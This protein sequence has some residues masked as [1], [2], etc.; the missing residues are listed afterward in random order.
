MPDTKCIAG[1]DHRLTL[2]RSAHHNII[3]VGLCQVALDFEVVCLE[4]HCLASLA[5]VGAGRTSC[6]CQ[7]LQSQQ[8]V[9]NDTE[10]TV[11]HNTCL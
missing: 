6:S 5:V 9:N 4:T 2:A 10:W 1:N 11:C 7:G 3:V 8:M